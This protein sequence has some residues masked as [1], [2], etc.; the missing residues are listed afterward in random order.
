[1]AT[2][3]A[4]EDKVD[5]PAADSMV[6]EN[7]KTEPNE[8]EE[9]EVT[10]EKLIS[11]IPDEYKEV[12]QC[13]QFADELEKLMQKNNIPGERILIQNEVSDYILYGKQTDKS[14]T[15]ISFLS[16]ITALFAALACSEGAA[17]RISAGKASQNN[18][19]PRNRKHSRPR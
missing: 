16:P 7:E 13:K 15:I 12:F 11:E 1:M 19:C 3:D 10:P 2:S 4:W 14:I 5:T 18:C 6:G 17:H 9:S 8:S